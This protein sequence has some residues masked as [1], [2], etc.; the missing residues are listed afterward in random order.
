MGWVRTW[1]GLDGGVCALIAVLNPT[2]LLKVDERANPVVSQYMLVLTNSSNA[3]VSEVHT[4]TPT[5]L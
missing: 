3:H 2:N 1:R 5:S 4:H